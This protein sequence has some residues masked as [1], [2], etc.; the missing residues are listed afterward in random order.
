M[1]SKDRPYDELYKQID[2]A[3]KPFGYTIDYFLWR[4]AKLKSQLAK[5][6]T[7]NGKILDVGGGT[8]IMAQFLPD[9]VDRKNY[10]DLDASMGILNY[11]PHNNILAVAEEIPCPD[12]FFDYVVLSEV[13]EH[14]NSKIKALNEC[15]RVLKP[16]R[17]LLL[18]T[19]RTGWK[20]GF[21]K[22]LSFHF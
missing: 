11:D 20:N 5:Y 18:S 12:N 14:V 17:L 10:Y 21:K 22:V 3:K 8:G 6:V 7:K 4:T 19:P 13:L 15:Y 9:F 1:N 2:M 16:K